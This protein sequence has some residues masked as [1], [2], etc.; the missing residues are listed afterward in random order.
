[1]ISF[2]LVLSFPGDGWDTYAACTPTRY[3]ALL[4]VGHLREK[5]PEADPK[6]REEE[7]WRRT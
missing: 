3:Q 4:Y 6:K 5:E 2:F 7:Q 1:M